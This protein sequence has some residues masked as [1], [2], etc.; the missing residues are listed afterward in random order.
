MKS[1]KQRRAQLK[2]KKVDR[3]AKRAAKQ[4]AAVR[5]AREWDASR[6]SPVDRS[7]L[8]P[9]NSYDVTDF[10]DRGYYLDKTFV[11]QGCGKE[12]LWTAT[13]QKWWYEVAKGDVFTTARLCRPCRRRERERRAEARRVH[14]EGIAR[15]RKECT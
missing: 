9:N 1:G 10:V 2:K 4:A 6:G 7:A 13:Q 5:D 12:E 14:L 11:C 8:A 15:K 3:A